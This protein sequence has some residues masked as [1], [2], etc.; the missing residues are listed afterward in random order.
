M[1]ILIIAQVLPLLFIA[2][3]HAGGCKS[4]GKCFNA[5]A[6]LDNALQNLIEQQTTSQGCSLVVD[7][8]D[9]PYKGSKLTY[10][11]LPASCQSGTTKKGL[12]VGPVLLKCGNVDASASLA[13]EAG[14]HDCG[15]YSQ[16]AGK[17]LNWSEKLVRSDTSAVPKGQVQGGTR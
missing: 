5:D 10:V 15:T 6:A 4:G 7:A 1:R 17:P 8:E 2:M 13:C 16:C 3:A 12:C 11:E 9:G 14:L